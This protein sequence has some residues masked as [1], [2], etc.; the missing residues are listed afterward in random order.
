MSSLLILSLLILPV[1]AGGHVIFQNNQ[2]RVFIRL[3][4]V[5]L[6]PLFPSSVIIYSIGISIIF[7]SV[8][9]RITSCLPQRSMTDIYYIEK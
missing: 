7:N 8:C 9:Q 2:L 6:A 1:F 4:D 3:K 5:I